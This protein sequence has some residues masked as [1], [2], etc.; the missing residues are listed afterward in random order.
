FL[1]AVHRTLTARGALAPRPVHGNVWATAVRAGLSVALALG[2]LY[3]AGHV[4]LIP[5]AAM[6]CFTALY[7]RDETYARRRVLLL[8]VGAALT[9][10]LALG[11][12]TQALVGHTLASVVVASVVAGG[13]KYLSDALALGAPA[14]LM[15]VFAVGVA[16]YNPLEP[17]QI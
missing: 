6:G 5:Y 7:A 16:A 12:L 13:A 9:L 2:A 14:G 8:V 3:A 11:A 15:F 4:E 10:S 17:A 1:G